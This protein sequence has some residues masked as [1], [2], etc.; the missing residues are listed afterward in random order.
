MCIQKEIFLHYVSEFHRSPRKNG[1]KAILEIS[2][3]TCI[4]FIAKCEID[5]GRME[6]KKDSAGQSHD[7]AVRVK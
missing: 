2:P 6:K 1:I 4:I 7:A 3:D 5:E